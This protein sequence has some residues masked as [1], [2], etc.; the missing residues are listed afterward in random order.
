MAMSTSAVYLASSS[1]AFERWPGQLL[2]DALGGNR[3]ALAW[4]LFGLFASEGLLLSFLGHR[5]GLYTLFLFLLLLPSLYTHSSLRWLEFAGLKV[6]PAQS[7]AVVGALG[8]GLVTGYL[9]IRMG[10]WISNMERDF[11]R[12]NASASDLRAAF[13]LSTG[14]LLVT[15][16]LATGLGLV[17]A[18]S[19]E[20]AG[21]L[22]SGFLGSI[23]LGVLTI[24]ITSVAMVAWAIG[25][26]IT[27]QDLLS[28]DLWRWRR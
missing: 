23:P 3:G 19:M 2:M 14:L 11:Q 28:S 21:K 15:L 4:A 20:S 25:R 18:I 22:F 9:V 5:P 7:E 12:R 8:V 17:L 16:G 6:E 27:S 10:I 24:G 1:F 26:L 13:C